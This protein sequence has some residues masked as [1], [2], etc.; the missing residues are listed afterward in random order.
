MIENAEISV[1]F[2]ALKE[3]LHAV[4]YRSIRLPVDDGTNE[5][6]K[7]KRVFTVI[8]FSNKSPKEI[9]EHHKKLKLS[10]NDISS[11]ECSFECFPIEET[12][13]WN[14]VA[15]FLTT[16]EQALFPEAKFHSINLSFRGIYS[17]F[18]GQEWPTFENLFATGDPIGRILSPEISTEF[19]RKLNKHR[20][21]FLAVKELLQARS[22]SSNYSSGVEIVFPTFA[23]IS[24]VLLQDGKLVISTT[25]GCPMPQFSVYVSR[26]PHG[27]QDNTEAIEGPLSSPL[28]K[29]FPE[30]LSWTVNAPELFFDDHVS[31]DL[32]LTHSSIKLDSFGGGLAAISPKPGAQE[33]RPE[34]KSRSAKKEVFETAFDQYKSVKRI[35]DGGSGQVFEV[36]NA[37][38]EHLALKIL[39]PSKATVDKVKRFKNEIDFCYRTSHKNIIRVLDYG[40]TYLKGAKATPFYVM[41][42]YPISLRG[43][44]KKG[45][46]KNHV[47]NLFSHLLGGIEE[48]HNQRVVHRDLKP[49]NV[50]CSGEDNLVIADFGIAHF[51]EEFLRTSVSSNGARLA[52]FQYA[53]P[54]Q[55]S[56][57]K[58]V[59][60]RCDIYALGL[61]LNEMVTK[62]VPQGTSY[63]TINEAD[64]SMGY[65]DAVVEK[66][67]RHNPVDR[68]STVREVREQIALSSK[69]IS[70]AN[71]SAMFPEL[72]PRCNQRFQPE[73]GW[74]DKTVCRHCG[75][76]LWP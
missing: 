67:I 6:L 56:P 9:T 58:E 11:L 8:R 64:P 35:G 5:P 28:G 61:I 55:R 75:F 2:N 60:Q 63:K 71:S 43:L 32:L 37:K 36:T 22:L 19:V 29:T 46:Q 72:C 7:R 34:P 47:L 17:S 40:I 15:E 24:Q 57:D 16:N 31:V 48:A 38:G 4:D 52:N 3:G 62:D 74:T 1:I 53:A 30:T 69:G 50:L 13:S 21:A 73:A 18:G 65:L 49:E 25:F 27:Y 12:T 41:P 68:F 23:K 54:E 59:D 45:M 14:N 10:V 20:E 33:A 70:V 51:E 42:L 66:M 76:Q 39:D 44:I 26:I